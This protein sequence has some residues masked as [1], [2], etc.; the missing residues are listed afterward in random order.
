MVDVEEL[1]QQAADVHARVV[2]DCGFDEAFTAYLER[3][4]RINQA[5][6]TI[7][8]GCPE[9][10]SDT[11][12]LGRRK[13]REQSTVIIAENLRELENITGGGL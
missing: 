10:G 4:E 13:P 3:S 6:E 12:H 5:A 9:C 7:H 2:C 11:V 8:F 1:K